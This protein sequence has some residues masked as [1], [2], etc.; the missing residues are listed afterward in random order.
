MKQI[1]N[2]FE[3][4][5]GKTIKSVDTSACNLQTLYFTD[6]TAALVEAENIGHGLHGPVWYV[7]DTEQIVPNRA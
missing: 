2:V 3:W 6:G 4:L 1:E 7:L 5:V